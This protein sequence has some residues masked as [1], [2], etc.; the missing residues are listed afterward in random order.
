MSH[1]IKIYP[2]CKSSYFRLWQL[3]ELITADVQNDLSA[4]DAGAEWLQH[5]VNTLGFGPQVPSLKPKRSTTEKLYLPS[6][7]C[8]HVLNQG[9]L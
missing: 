2:V 5:L 4:G 3:K 7:K 1:L 6:N 9:Q 8:I